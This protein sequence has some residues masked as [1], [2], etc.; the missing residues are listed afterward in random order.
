MSTLDAR[1]HF[2]ALV[3]AVEAEPQTFP[4][5]GYDDVPGANGNGG[6]TPPLYVSLTVERRYSPGGRAGRAGTRGWRATARAVGY[7]EAECRLVLLT[8]ANALD[9]AELT[10]AGVRSTPAR[11]ESEQSPEFD[12]ARYSALAVYTYTL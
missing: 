6:T 12:D 4:V 5:L 7:S 8:V 11:L 2:A 1:A 10:V 9:G 3:A